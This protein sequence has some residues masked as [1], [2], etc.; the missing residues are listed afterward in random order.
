MNGGNQMKCTIIYNTMTNT[1]RNPVNK[2]K[3]KMKKKKLRMDEESNHKKL[4]KT[5]IKILTAFIFD[6]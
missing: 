1:S 3:I 5:L 4:R 6:T 2:K